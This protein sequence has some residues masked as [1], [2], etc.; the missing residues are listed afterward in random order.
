VL[1]AAGTRLFPEKSYGFAPTNVEEAL[2]AIVEGR[3]DLAINISKLTE[4]TLKAVQA[5]YSSIF[6]DVDAIKAAINDYNMTKGQTFSYE[7]EKTKEQCDEVE[8]FLASKAWPKNEIPLKEVMEFLLT[9]PAV[10]VKLNIDVF[11]ACMI[12]FNGRDPKPAPPFSILEDVNVNKDVFAEPIDVPSDGW[13][14]YHA[15]KLKEEPYSTDDTTSK[16]IGEIKNWI[17]RPENKANR[18]N[19]WG[20]TYATSGMKGASDP[21]TYD[22]YINQLDRTPGKMWANPELGIGAAV[23]NIIGKPLNI[24]DTNGGTYKLI[25]APYTP[26]AYAPPSASSPIDGTNILFVSDN[27]YN[28]LIPQTEA[29]ADPNLVG[30]LKA[31]ASMMKA[32]GTAEKI[33]AD[34][35][36]VADAD[37]VITG[38][39]GKFT[40]FVG[41]YTDLS[42]DN[43]KRAAIVKSADE[44]VQLMRDIADVLKTSTSDAGKAKTNLK[45]KSNALNA[46]KAGGGRAQSRKHHTTRKAG[47]KNTHRKIRKA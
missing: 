24:W 2:L 15:I 16:F 37:A 17:M 1:D 10:G 31:K 26:D 27:H 28:R 7:V 36:I 12:D 13:C 18:E 39:I 33:K 40:A 9:P 20:P 29:N 3:S 41:S 21:A 32:Q 22:E 4:D 11:K 14:F 5:K 43:A 42:L 8:K 19:I 47:R 45:A 23:A 46:I 30:L 44:M 35:T 6:A 38:L 25:G 34:P